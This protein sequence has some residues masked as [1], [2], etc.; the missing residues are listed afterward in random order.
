VQR[1]LLRRT[2][3]G[4][5]FLPLAFLFALYLFALA[6]TL[7]LGHFPRCSTD[8][9]KYLGLGFFYHLVWPLAATTFYSAPVW[10]VLWIRKLMAKQRARREVLLYALGWLLVLVQLVLDPFSTLC[11]YA[12]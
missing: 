1:D 8:D 12:D 9:P 10:L 11:W 3:H 6:A 5:S 2:F 7:Q 4:L